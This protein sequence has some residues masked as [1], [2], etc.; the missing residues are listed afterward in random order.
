VPPTVPASL[1][2]VR[3]YEPGDA[4]PLQEAVLESLD[5]LRPWLPWVSHEP[6]TLGQRQG[7]IATWQSRW[8]AGDR[9]CGMFAG[10]ELVGGCGLHRRI[11]PGGLEIGYWVRVGRT[12]RG[13][14]T[15]AARQLTAMA[16]ALPGVTHVEIHHD[17]TNLAS[18][19]V[20]AKLGFTLVEQRSRPSAAPAETG[21]ENIWRLERS[22]TGRGPDPASR[23]P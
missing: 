19:R 7:L 23:R 20:P 6:L 5:H 22:S 17:V 1:L 15:E 11:G 21:T 9:M 3:R 10:A 16:F 12:G 4:A 2:V 13:Y 8:D 18:G 14:A